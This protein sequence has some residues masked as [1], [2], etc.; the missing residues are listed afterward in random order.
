M[1]PGETGPPTRASARRVRFE[2]EAGDDGI[3]LDQ[4]VA[5]HVPEL[6]RRKARL[7]IELGGVFLDRARVKVLGRKVRPGQQVD[8]HLGGAVDRATGSLG[9]AARA[10]DAARLP[11]LP[12]VFE[13]EHL[14]VVDKPSGLLTA[15]TPES[16]RNNVADVL[17]RR[18]EP[19]ESIYVVHRLDMETSGLLVLA[20]TEAA[21]RSLS[22]SFRVHDVDRAYLAVAQ[23][24]LADEIGRIES[25]I[26]GRPAVSHVSVVQRGTDATLLRVGLETGRTHQVRIHLQSVGHS[27]CG[28]RRYGEPRGLAPPRLALHAARLGFAHPVSGAPLV[29]D[30]RWPADLASWWGRRASGEPS[31]VPPG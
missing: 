6:S 16:D 14:I 11:D 9:T 3:R 8:V 25:P 12:V 15:P 31:V 17:A 21:N 4:V 28:D 13:D 5:R 18:S 19:R 24:V 23:G 20:R 1:V 30:S 26:G 29:F 10:R 2:V 7:V 27:I 22:E